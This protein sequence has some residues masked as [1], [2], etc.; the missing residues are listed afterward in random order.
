VT[1]ALAA[2]ISVV[3]GHVCSATGTF[4]HHLRISCASPFSDAIDRALLTLGRICGD[5]HR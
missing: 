4:R 3:P 5:L 1:R 2:D